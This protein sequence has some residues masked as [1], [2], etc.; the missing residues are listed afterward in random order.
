[1]LIT[2]DI[3]SGFVPQTNDAMLNKFE[4][5]HVKSFTQ[6]SAKEFAESIAKACTT[7]QTFI[8]VVINSYGGQ[9]HALMSMLDTMAACELPIYT[10]CQGVA[11]SCG[12]FL[13]AFGDKRFAT[14][15]SSIMIHSIALGA[16]GKLADVESSSA[17]GRRLSTE[18]WARLDSRCNQKS[19]YFESLLK[20]NENADLYLTPKQAKK[21]NLIDKVKTPTIQVTAEVKYKLN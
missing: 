15:S 1:M 5:V 6:D 17:H 12:A 16:I 7:G 20:D 3:G 19:G 9:V 10:I 18:L 8:P 21:H 4:V 13:L 11:M 2:Y 14:P